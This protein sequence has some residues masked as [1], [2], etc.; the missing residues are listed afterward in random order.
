[1]KGIS[2]ILAMILI[3][4]IV[5]ALIGMTYTFATGLFSS[6]SEVTKN[7]T[8][9]I[10]GNMGKSVSIVAAKCMSGATGNYTFSI[11][12]T[13]SNSIAD[14]ELAA[15]ADGSKLTVTFSALPVGQIMQFNSTNFNI[16]SNPH[17]LKVSAPAGEVQTTLTC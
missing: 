4:I 7:Q 6:T 10:T 11:R 12:N 3:V 1:M 8:T 13:G 15:F 5:V 9:Q 14:T 2:E 16:G 17:T